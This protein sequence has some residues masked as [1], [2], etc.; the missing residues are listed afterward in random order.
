LGLAHRQHSSQTVGVRVPFPQVIAAT[1]FMILSDLLAAEPHDPSEFEPEIRK[2]EIVD[3]RTPPPSH[4]ILFTGSSSIRLWTNVATA[5]PGE[6]ILNRGFGGSTFKDLLVY[7]DR[8]VLP[9]HP[10]A[11]VVYEGDNDLA[12]EVSAA[13]VAADA[14][15]FLDRV[16][17]QLTGTPVIFLAV[18]PSPKRRTLLK[19]QQDLNDRL[20]ALAR[21]RPSV[22]FADTFLPIL[23]AQGEPDPQYFQPDGLHLTPL[24]YAAWQPAISAALQ[25]LHLL[26]PTP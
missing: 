2:Y 20:K 19:A 6:V 14:I 11:V 13:S 18:K 12:G 24:G 7:F 4:P 23:D 10:R 3:R 26:P 15:K 22:L 17:R 8:I 1:L 5:F 21:L 9:Y 25:Q 16:E